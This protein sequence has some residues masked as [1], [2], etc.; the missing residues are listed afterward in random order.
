MRIFDRPGFPNPARIRIVLAE[1]GLDP[2]IEFVPVDLIGAEHKQPAFLEKNPSG[3]VPV[4]QLDDGTYIAECTAITEYLD[5][6]DGDPWLTGRT[7]KEKAVIHMMQK[8]AETEL[9]DAVGNH[10]HHA[11]PGLGAELQAF[12]SPEWAGRQE[13]GFR[14]RDKALAGMTYF[15]TVLQ[16]HP[17]VA[18][19]A[20]SMADITVFAGLMFADA[21]GIAM[22]EDHSAL[23]AWRAR[24]AELPSVKN[25]SG[26]MFV[27]ADLRR[28][29]F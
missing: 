20:F 12:K 5:N 4:L 1:K 3:V 8:R 21:A 14:Q 28:L 29:G 2:L 13:W 23:R 10:F 11:T 9:L 15:D 6:L 22:P 19:D 25:R 24:V 18:G 27:A 16:S 26:Q 17:F 7:P